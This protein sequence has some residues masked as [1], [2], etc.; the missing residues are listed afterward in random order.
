MKVGDE[1]VDTHIEFVAIKEERIGDILLDN[2]VIGVVEFWEVTDNFDTSSP[3][4]PD[5]FHD[6][7]VA[8]PVEHFLLVIL[9]A[10]LGVLLGQIES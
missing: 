7:V 3:G 4:L 8:V 10:E 6:P 9:F 2:N 5:G 1:Y